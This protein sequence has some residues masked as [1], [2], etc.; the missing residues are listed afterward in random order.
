MFTSD[1]AFASFKVYEA[2]LSQSKWVFDGNPLGCQLSHTIPSYGDA[3]FSKQPGKNK[4]LEFNLTYKRQPIT[5]VKVASIQSM[6]PAWLPDQPA[7]YLGETAIEN[8]PSIFKTKNIASWKL[9]NELEIGRFPTFQY[10]EFNSLEDQVA[11]SISAVGFKQ[12]YDEF[13]NCM[14]SLVKHRLDELTKMT[15]H[16]DF[17]K[18]SVRVKYLEKLNSLSAYVKY[19]PNLEIVFI[20]GHTDSKGSRS[21]NERLAQKR[22]NTVKKLLSSHGAEESQFKTV[23]YGEKNPVASNRKS[24]GRALN[25]RVYIRVSQH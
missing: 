6:S 3:I 22:I 15:L 16:F 18:S 21:Y 20:G 23:A 11:V 1:L 5:S 14:A 8:G 2:E 10:Q 12:P 13:L 25:R 19:D 17:D 24:S 7:R 4:A 9:L